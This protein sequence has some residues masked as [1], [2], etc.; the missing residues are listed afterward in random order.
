MLFAHLRRTNAD[1]ARRV[2]SIEPGRWADPTPCA[3]WDV[4]ALVSHPAGERD[5]PAAP[6]RVATAPSSW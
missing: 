2:R 3:E 5:L 4:R 6:A 1:F